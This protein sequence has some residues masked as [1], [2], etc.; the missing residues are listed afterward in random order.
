MTSTGREKSGV[1]LKFS[2]QPAPAW[3][4]DGG[5]LEPTYP[6]PVVVLEYKTVVFSSVTYH[7]NGRRLKMRIII[8]TFL[9]LS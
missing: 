7:Q 6:V 1:E 5:C 3:H 9:L 2:F 8:I 4:S